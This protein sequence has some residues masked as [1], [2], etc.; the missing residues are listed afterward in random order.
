MIAFK[1]GD[2]IT[3]R[4]NKIGVHDTAPVVAVIAPLFN[5]LVHGI[6]VKYLLP[7]TERRVLLAILD[8]EFRKNP[9]IQIELNRFVYLKQLFA[10]EDME[11]AL[12][13]P[14][15]FYTRYIKPIMQSD[16]YRTYHPMYMSGIRILTNKQIVLTAMRRI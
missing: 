16:S 12:K 14:Q 4:Y 5:N 15:A 7:G 2:L 1:T 8:E 11:N 10:T 3:F 13:I 6:N 9:Q